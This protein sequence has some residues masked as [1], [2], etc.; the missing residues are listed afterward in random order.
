MSPPL[1]IGVGTRLGRDDAIGLVLVE[2]LLSAGAV[3]ASDALVL[4]GADAAT[5]AATLLEVE[6][7]ILVVDCADMGAPPGTVRVFDDTEAKL[8]LRDDGTSTHGFG[9]AEGLALARALGFGFR[10]RVL[11]VQPFDLSPGRSLSDEMR[12]VLDSL[13]R[14]LET[15]LSSY[16][17]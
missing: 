1:V 2:R 15:A 6:R 13:D 12:A 17:G 4:E 7:D 3:E 9:L 10:V 8:A 11:A 5:V 14:T 16:G